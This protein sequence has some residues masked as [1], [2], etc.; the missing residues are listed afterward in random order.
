MPSKIYLIRHGE[1]DY[2]RER[3]MQGWLDIPLN[4][5]GHEQARLAA[6]TLKGH[7]IHALYSS[8]LVRAKQTAE[9]IAATLNLEINLSKNLR[10][11]DMGI[12]AGWAWEKERDE[13]K[14]KIWAEFEA[15]RDLADPKW[16][17]HK[18]E[19]VGEMTERITQFFNQIEV[20]HAR[21]SV[22]VVTHG[23]TVNRILEHFEIKK[24]EEGF[25]MIKNASVIIL[26]R[27]KQGY[28]Y[29]ELSTSDLNISTNKDY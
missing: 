12:F 16:K 27:N 5:L 23:G 2:N 24:P 6:T 25:R 10:E 3:R 28:L 19:S 20:V 17:K 15:A 8:D 9:P 22:A 26:T 29:E 11:R 21:E 13:V 18:G 1:T 14:D 7:L 4:E